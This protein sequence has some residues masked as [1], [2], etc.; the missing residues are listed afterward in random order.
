MQGKLKQLTVEIG[1]RE[2]ADMYFVRVLPLKLQSWPNKQPRSASPPSLGFSQGGF[3]LTDRAPI[4][5][6]PV[7]TVSNRPA[8]AS[9]PAGRTITIYLRVS[10]TWHFTQAQAQIVSLAVVCIYPAV[11][12]P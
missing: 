12:W 1:R 6:F 2:A 7:S 4:G 9:Q 10:W 3:R 11:L 5:I 8:S